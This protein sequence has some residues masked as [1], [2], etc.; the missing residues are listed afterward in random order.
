MV[1]LAGKHTRA[2]QASS[3]SALCDPWHCAPG[4]RVG[5]RS[6]ERS[7]V[8]YFGRT[9]AIGARRF[10]GSKSAGV[11]HAAEIDIKKVLFRV[12]GSGSILNPLTATVLREIFNP[13]SCNETRKPVPN[14]Q[15]PRNTIA[16][17][18]AKEPV[19]FAR[20]LLYEWDSLSSHRRQLIHIPQTSESEL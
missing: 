19:L 15:A 7:L 8:A 14:T 20:G 12:N 13:F 11:N 2:S 17:G 1:C 4:L 5:R 6:A 3:K 9:A 10:I 18:V 16:E